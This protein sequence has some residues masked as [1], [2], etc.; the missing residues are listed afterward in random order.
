MD[1][2]W[3]I[4]FDFRDKNLSEGPPKHLQK[5]PNLAFNKEKSNKDNTKIIGDFVCR[6]SEPFLWVPP[7]D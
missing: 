7:P 6:I 5:N 2:W 1:Q 4:L 3:K